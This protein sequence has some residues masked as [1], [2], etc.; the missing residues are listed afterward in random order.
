MMSIFV[1]LPSKQKL[2]DKYHKNWLAI[3]IA[4][5]QSD[6]IIAEEVLEGSLMKIILEGTWFAVIQW[7]SAK[8]WPITG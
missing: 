8:G 6:S 4:E 5:V 2:C 1:Y 7:Q 3:Y